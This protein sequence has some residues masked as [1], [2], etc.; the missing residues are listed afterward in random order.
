MESVTHENHNVPSADTEDTSVDQNLEFL[1][2]TLNKKGA[3]HFGS[4]LTDREKILR[5]V[6]FHKICEH[7]MH[8]Y[9]TCR[10]LG[11]SM[12]DFCEN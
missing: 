1:L 9:L 10:L 5:I 12:R 7:W 11:W 2:M 8:K 3:D 4:N 6:E